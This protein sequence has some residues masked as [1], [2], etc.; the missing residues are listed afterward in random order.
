MS[1]SAFRVTTT[2][3]PAGII[4]GYTFKLSPPSEPDSTSSPKHPDS[5]A[6]L[7]TKTI[8]IALETSMSLRRR[9][10]LLNDMV[11]ISFLEDGTYIPQKDKVMNEPLAGFIDG[12]CTP[13]SKI[14]G[15]CTVYL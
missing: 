4:D 1:T 8:R 3:S 13:R 10:V 6:R 15:N 14:A 11:R 9:I 12:N 2:H 5:D 7:I